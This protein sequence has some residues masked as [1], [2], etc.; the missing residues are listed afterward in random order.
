MVSP[1]ALSLLT[2]AS[3]EGPARTTALSLWQAA[4][5][6]GATTGIIAGGVLTQYL[7]WRAIFLVNP[8]LIAIMLAFVPR[9]P[10]AP[11]TR[12]NRIDVRGAMLV[13]AAIAALIYGLAE[14]QQRG[15][16]APLSIA[17]LVA[18]CLLATLFIYSERTVAAPMLPPSLM[19]GYRLSYLIG[20]G[21]CAV[22]FALVS[23]R[24]PRGER[25]RDFAPAATE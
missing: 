8:P 11:A 10:A 13:T 15:F 5:A 4:T 17:A 24:L 14:G 9:L 23:T 12:D 21:L 6:S 16:A 2:T 22:A 7:G 18:C 19:A 1:A 25:P 3:P 20:A